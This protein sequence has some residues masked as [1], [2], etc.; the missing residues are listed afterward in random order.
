MPPCP[1]INVIKKVSEVTYKGLQR[2]WRDRSE[3]RVQLSA[4]TAAH[5]HAVEEIW[6]PLLPFMDIAHMWYTDV[7]RQNSH[8]NK[9]KAIFFR[10]ELK[11]DQIGLLYKE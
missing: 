8:M 7:C 2:G 1:L 4:P 6:C 10:E 11:K 5:N 3:E 9:L